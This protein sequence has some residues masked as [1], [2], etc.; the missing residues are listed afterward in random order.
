MVFTILAHSRFP[1]QGS[2]L[3]YAE[4]FRGQGTEWNFSYTGW[5][6]SGDLPMRS[7]ETLSLTITPL[8]E[9]SIRVP[10]SVVRWSKEQEFAVDALSINPNTQAKRDHDVKRPVYKPVPVFQSKS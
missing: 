5:R 10:E 1:V 7:G 3:S 8:D 9:Q 2:V 4:P 6:P